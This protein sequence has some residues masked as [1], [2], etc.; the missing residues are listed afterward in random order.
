LDEAE[1]IAWQ[2]V[3]DEIAAG[4]PGNT[5]CPFCETAPMKVESLDGYGAD[6]G[7]AG[8]RMKISCNNC[9]KFVEGSFGGF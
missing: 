8:G 6:V 7:V 3:F 1:V 5:R 4:R 9:G 2:D